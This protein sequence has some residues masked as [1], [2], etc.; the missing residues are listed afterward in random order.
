MNNAFFGNRLRRKPRLEASL[1]ENPY[2][3]TGNLNIGWLHNCHEEV[4]VINS[5]LPGGA[6]AP[7]SSPS[8]AKG[9]ENVALARGFPHKRR[10][11]TKAW[12]RSRT[13][14]KRQTKCTILSLCFQLTTACS[15]KENRPDH[16]IRPANTLLMLAVFLPH[17]QGVRSAERLTLPCR[18]HPM[19]RIR[20]KGPQA[21]M[22][23]RQPGSYRHGKHS[24][25]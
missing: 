6:L 23:S 11:T 14:N 12:K 20:R 25:C 16:A 24:R 18:R 3:T 8:G 15:L 22:W 2:N 7:D 5:P 21:S 19:R 1:A 17:T 10:S 4:G 9:G 13:D